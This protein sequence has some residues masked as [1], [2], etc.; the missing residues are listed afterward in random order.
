M[1]MCHIILSSVACLVLPYFSTLSHKRHDFQKKGTEP[2]YMFW[3]SLQLL[4][5]KLLVLR[6]IQRHIITKVHIL[7][8]HLHR[9]G[10]LPSSQC[11]FCDHDT[12]DIYFHVQSLQK[13]ES[14]HL[15]HNRIHLLGSTVPNGRNV[16]SGRWIRRRRQM[17]I[18]HHVHY[19]LVLSDFNEMWIFLTDFWK[20]LKYQ[21]SWKSVQ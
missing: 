21:I 9:I 5:E 4:S 19:P 15:H 17:Y 16:K 20:I 10:V 18:Y 11:L 8:S 1:H 6:R 7:A 13:L 2:K 3:F 12:L 14:H